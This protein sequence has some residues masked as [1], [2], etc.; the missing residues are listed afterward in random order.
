MYPRRDDEEGKTN[1]KII[2]ISRNRL[3]CMCGATRNKEGI[4]RQFWANNIG[5]NYMA[6]TKSVHEKDWRSHSMRR[7]F[8]LYAVIQF[9]ALFGTMP[10]IGTTY[11]AHTLVRRWCGDP[12]GR[13]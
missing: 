10:S 8:Q 4:G 2:K 7:L 12:A 11:A 1:N 13:G 9:G 5:V 3:L 6:W